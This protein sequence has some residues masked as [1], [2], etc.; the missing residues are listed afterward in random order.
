MKHRLSLLLGMLFM[1]KLIMAQDLSN[2][3]AIEPLIA[4]LT[5]SVNKLQDQFGFESDQ[6]SG[7]YEINE[8]TRVNQILFQEEPDPGAFVALVS[9]PILV[10]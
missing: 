6:F 4:T 10:I 5:R 2:T 3:E 7:V 9:M 8:K 1:A